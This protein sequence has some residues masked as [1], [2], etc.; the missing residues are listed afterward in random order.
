FSSGNDKIDFRA[1][2]ATTFTTFKTGSLATANSVVAAH[3]I[4]WFSFFDSTISHT[5]T[6]VYAN[7][8]DGALNGGSSSLLEIHLTGVSSV[9]AGDFLTTNPLNLIAPA[10]VAG[11]PINLGLAAPL[12][13]DG[14]LLT[15]AIADLPSGWT[16]SAGTLLEGAALAG[17]R[18]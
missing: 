12:T 16:L 11:E 3:T 15:T 1:F 13:Q 8:T 10:G 5:S 17:Q 6:I 9:Q 2:G 7:P 4:A 18:R 14:T